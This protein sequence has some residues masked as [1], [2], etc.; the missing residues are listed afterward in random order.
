MLNFYPYKGMTKNNYLDQWWTYE[1]EWL[2]GNLSFNGGRIVI[3]INK[4]IF[5]STQSK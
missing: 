2:T 5:T 3:H 1:N 4:S